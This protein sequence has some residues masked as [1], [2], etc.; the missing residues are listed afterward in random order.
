MAAKSSIKT[1][2]AYELHTDGGIDAEPGQSTGE[3]SIGVVLT[4]PDGSVVH[5]ISDRIGWV[6]DH[7]VA[8]YEALIAG[9]RL[10]R[11]HGVDRLRVRVDSELVVK[12]LSGKSKVQAT[13]LK[14]LW[15]SALSLRAEFS[16]IDISWVPRKENK[17]ADELAD[18]A[19][20]PRRWGSK[21][22]S[23]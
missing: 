17:L 21:G 7:H 3:A 14:S 12:Q 20:Q 15:R 5:E 23:A 2:H 19:L 8:E 1:R 18:R 10:A 13:H 9:L 16:E 22:S 11:G 4:A 6:A